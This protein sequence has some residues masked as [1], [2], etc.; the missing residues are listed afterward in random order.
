MLKGNFKKKELFDFIISKSK[1]FEINISESSIA[2][3]LYGGII[4]YNET[5]HEPV[6]K[7][8]APHGMNLTIINKINKVNKS[9]LENIS[10]ED[11][12]LQS[13]NNASF[14]KSLFTTDHDLLSNSLKNNVFEKKLVQNI[15]WFEDIKKMSYFNNVYAVGFSHY[16]ETVFILNP[17]T[18]IKSLVILS[19]SALCK[20]TLLITGIISKSYSKAL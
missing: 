8:Y 7:L 3:I 20:S 10:A 16:G 15:E 14:I 11:F 1:K 12:F 2:A 4:L 5:L 6:Q 13:T 17:N 18:L 19:V 9:A